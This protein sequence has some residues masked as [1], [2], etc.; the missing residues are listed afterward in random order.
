MFD[1]LPKKNSQE[2]E[3]MSAENKPTAWVR[4]FVSF[5]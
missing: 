5:L 2:D 3:L 4:Y 1:D